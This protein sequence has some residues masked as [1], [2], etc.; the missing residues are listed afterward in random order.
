MRVEGHL[1]VKAGPHRRIMQ[2]QASRKAGP[3]N[4]QRQSPRNVSINIYDSIWPHSR[5]QRGW[6][7]APHCSHL[8]RQRT[9]QAVFLVHRS[10]MV[11]HA[12]DTKRYFLRCASVEEAGAGAEEQGR[13][14]VDCL[15]D[16]VVTLTLFRNL[17]IY[18]FRVEGDGVSLKMAQCCTG[19]SDPRGG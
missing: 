15:V 9:A 17:R 14:P 19:P 1:R 5:V 8:L 13:D 18:C 10:L 12:M 16:P 11:R 6:S 3:A 4:K 7:V 2:C